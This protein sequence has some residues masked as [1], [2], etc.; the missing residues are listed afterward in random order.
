MRVILSKYTAEYITP[1]PSGN[2]FLSRSKRLQECRSSTP[3]FTSFIYYNFPLAYSPLVTLGSLYFLC[4]LLTQ[5]SSIQ[6]L[7]FLLI[8]VRST[9]KCH[10]NYLNYRHWRLKNTPFL[11]FPFHLL[12]FNFLQ[13]TNN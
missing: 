8:L 13:I 12:R 7:G 6:W 9:L 10:L 2:F 1:K 3:S 5:S 4:P 11:V